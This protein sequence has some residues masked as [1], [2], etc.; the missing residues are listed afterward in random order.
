MAKAPIMRP[1]ASHIV[2]CTLSV[3]YHPYDEDCVI[4]VP[5]GRMKKYLHAIYSLHSSASPDLSIFQLQFLLKTIIL[6]KA[7]FN[8]SSIIFPTIS[9]KL[10][11]IK[12]NG[13]I[14]DI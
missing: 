10:L 5:L 9:Q 1:E 4:L 8:C 12:Y 14:V 11:T 2:A 13:H 6:Q 3:V 7:S